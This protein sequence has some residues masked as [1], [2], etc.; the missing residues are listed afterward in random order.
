[1]IEYILSTDSLWTLT[2]LMYCLAAVHLRAF[3][4]RDHPL[5]VW[6]SFLAVGSTL[7]LLVNVSPLFPTGS[8]VVLV[9]EYATIF[10]AAT[11]GFVLFLVELEY[12]EARERLE[13]YHKLDEYYTDDE[14]YPKRQDD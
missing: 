6:G 9:I 14:F 5:K 3:D 10:A 7:F 13:Q 8:G 12:A 4:K 11:V 2:A 1:M